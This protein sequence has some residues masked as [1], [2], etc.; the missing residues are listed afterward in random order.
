M[1]DQVTLLQV[2]PSLETIITSSAG[3]SYMTV[4]QTVARGQHTGHTL[5]MG[6]PILPG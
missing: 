5:A 1:L 4:M 2:L 6:Q 3:Y